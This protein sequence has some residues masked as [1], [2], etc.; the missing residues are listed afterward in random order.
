MFFKDYPDRVRHLVMIFGDQLDHDAE[1]LEK[2][3]PDQDAVLM[4]EVRHEA[5]YIPQHA[6]RLVLFF[7][8]MRH[9]ATELRDR[10]FPV[11]YV[12]LQDRNNRGDFSSEL[13]RWINKTRPEAV[14]ATL[15]GDYRVLKLLQDVCGER[16]VA[17]DVADDQHFLDD[18]DGFR[19]W[20][21]GRKRLR[22]EDYYRHL[23]KRSGWLVT[24]DGEPA[25]GQWNYDRDNRDTFGREGPPQIKSPRKFRHDAVTE[26]VVDMVAAEFPDA[27]G[28]ATAFDY[29]VTHDQARAAL[30]DF[31]EHRLPQFG[32]YQDAMAAGHPYLFH[33]RLSAALNLHLLSPRACIEAAIAAWEAGD[34]PLNS[35]EG[36]VRQILGWR[37]YIRG[38][39]WL[40]MPQYAELNELDADRPVP[41]F[42]WDGETDM[43]CVRDAVTQL[44]ETAYAHH[45]QRLMVLG[46]FGLLLGCDPYQMHQWHLSMYADAID[47]V[48]LPNVLG[49][50]QYGDGGIVGSKPYSASGNYIN[51]MSDYCV[52]CR[53]QYDQA[54]GEDACPFTTLYWDFLSRNRNR[55]KHNRRMQFQF[56]NLDRKSDSERR[57]IR[58]QARKLKESF[59]AN[60]Y[61]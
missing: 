33:S 23:R 58:D 57:A 59:K 10:G 22:L 29:P 28:E 52:D 53:Y 32:T 2:L 16:D 25:G 50:S 15:P 46:E 42:L 30:R 4:L 60:T 39:Y 24:G 37:E 43:A 36:F 27:P 35:V 11:I 12:D 9:F 44:K 31:I 8:A 40:K 55:L 20:A 54:A 6:Q 51:R 26:T 1:L 7:S 17:L 48:S 19:Q 18:P 5:E 41:A 34:A 21:E 14:R 47:W 38:I 45:I 49:M 61:L 3:D 13:S 56:S